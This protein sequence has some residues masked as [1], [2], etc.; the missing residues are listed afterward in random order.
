[1]TV[2]MKLTPLFLLLAATLHAADAPPPVDFRVTDA[3]PKYVTADV[4]FRDGTG[5]KWPNFFYGK[6][7]GDAGHISLDAAKPAAAFTLL[8][9]KMAQ[10]KGDQSRKVLGEISTPEKPPAITLTVTGIS[11][12]QPAAGKDKDK[13]ALTADLTGTLEVAG[14]KT[15]F[16]AAAT[17]RHHN[18]KGD[19]KNTAL[20]LDARATIAP[21]ALGLKAITTPVEMR[22][23]LTAYPA[24]AASSPAKK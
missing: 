1:M 13:P 18:G 3:F 12:L 14:R 8:C 10:D 21:A 20:M 4:E 17:L 6:P 9:D 5:A 22:L 7:V 11:A 15:P 2:A 16:K 19:E 23:G 24:Q